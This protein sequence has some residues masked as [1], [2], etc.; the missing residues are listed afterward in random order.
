M[1]VIADEGVI[2]TSVSSEDFTPKILIFED[3]AEDSSELVTVIV[4]TS[5]P[6]EPVI[7]T[8]TGGVPTLA[9]RVS[10]P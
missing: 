9:P 2:A 4:T 3:V 10:S 8:E 7:A 1:P 6:A 5:E